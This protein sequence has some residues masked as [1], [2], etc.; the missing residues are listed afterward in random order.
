MKYLI[1]LL[2]Y[3]FPNPDDNASLAHSFE[4]TVNKF[5]DN[6]FIYFE[7]EI[8]T[9]SQTNDASNKLAYKLVEDGVCHSDRVVL[10]MENRSDYIITILAL[11]KIGAI[12]VLINTSLTG[13]PL[14]HCI[15]SSDSKKCI[16]GAELASSLEGVLDAININD[17]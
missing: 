11:N 2:R 3:K 10:F 9:Y 4:E 14:I 6:N 15:N 17:K 5:G 16:V 7:E 13:K 8:W 12:G 1:P